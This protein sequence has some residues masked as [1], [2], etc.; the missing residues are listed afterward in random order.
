M[1]TFPKYI[2]FHASRSPV[3]AEYDARGFPT[4][5]FSSGIMNMSY[6]F[7]PKG[8]LDYRQDHLTG[9]RETFGYDPLN[10]LT[11]WTV[12]YN[13]VWQ[14]SNSLTYNATTG[15][16]SSKS[17][18][19]NYAMNYGE[20]GQPPRALTSIDGIPSAINTNQTIT[21][22]DFK[23]V[24]QI[25]NGTESLNIT[26]GVDEQRIKAIK[27]QPSGTLTRYYMGNYE[28]EVQSNSTR[29]IHYIA[30]GNGLAAIYVQNAGYDTLYYAHTDYQGSLIA[31]SLP[32]G[33]VKERYAYDPWGNRRNPTQWSQPDFRTAFVLNRGYTLHEHLPEFGLINMNGRV[34]DPSVSQFLSLDP[35][36]QDPGNWLNYNRYSYALNN[37]LVY[38][39]P[40][41]K[42][43]LLALFLFHTDMGYAVQ[44]WVSPVAV[45]YNVHTGSDV[46]GFGVD[47]SIGGSQLSPVSN[48]WHWGA[49]HYS[50]Y[51]DTG[52]TGWETRS[53]SEVTITPYF[54]Y[55]GTKFK[56]GDLD[57]TTNLVT[58]GGPFANI[59]YENDFE[60]KEL[61]WI[62]GVPKG[63]SDK[64]RTAAFQFNVFEH[65][66]GLN[67]MTGDPGNGESEGE[68]GKKVYIE[69]GE[70]Y[71]LGALYVKGGPLRLGW[72][73]EGIRSGIQDPIH[74]KRNTPRFSKEKLNRPFWFFGTGSGNTL[75]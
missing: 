64:Y 1:K 44:K 2:M 57:Q 62:P 54:S 67:L 12:Y 13:N 46:K 51:Y 33:T 52:F 16:I 15:L 8:N 6:S 32:N 9:N 10:R 19:G 29:K 61:R 65:G 3:W 40:D 66:I 58:I 11:D 48:R 41:G 71:R 38:T 31:L 26:Y 68:E 4:S 63:D 21:Y 42:F 49:T 69:E 74:D 50:K 72:N 14:A 35:Y 36:V 75:W 5:I 20:A 37:P 43:V 60:I 7:T 18:L 30:G 23:K 56:F 59:K 55:S 25:T 39:D 45:R 34:Y 73:S 28:E 70:K 27:T 53:G 22:T 17:E 24:K 47:V